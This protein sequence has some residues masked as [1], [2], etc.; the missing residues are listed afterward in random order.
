MKIIAA[1][2]LVGAGAGVLAGC[3]DDEPSTEEATAQ[4]C[5]ARQS[6]NETLTD[7]G[8]LDPTDS[9]QLAEARDNISNDVDEL[10][11]AGKKLA[12]S[13]WN[14]VEQAWDGFRD[15]VDNLDQD[16]TFA[17]ARQQLTSAMEE[18]TSAWDQF[19]SKVDC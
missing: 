10:S 13:E 2:V 3:G 11:S 12:E 9:S 14:D 5:D 17:E 18:L 4:V 1:L 16:T 7:L 6:L 15:T 8:D 19:T